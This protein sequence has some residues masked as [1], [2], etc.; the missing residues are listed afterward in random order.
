MLSILDTFPYPYR[1]R[2]AQQL[3]VTLSQLHPTPQG[4]ILIA[5]QAGLDGTLIDAGQPP[6]FVWKDVLGLAGR[7]GLTRQLVQL[8]HDKLNATNPRRPFLAGLLSGKPTPADDEPRADGGAPNFLRDTD[9]V[10][11]DE[12]L[13]YHD[14]LT[15]QIGRLPDFIDTLQRMV[16]LAPAVC[17]LT[18]D[19]HGA[20]MLG[21][22]FRIGPDLLLTNWHVVYNTLTGARATAVTAEFGYEH[23][24]RG[25]AL[26]A[27]I[28]TCDVESIVPGQADD[29]AV[30][31]ATDPLSDAWPVVKLSEAVTPEKGSAAYVIQHPGGERKRLGFVR[32]TVTAFDERTMHYLTDT[33][34]GSS[35]APVF[36]PRGR[37]IALHHAG[38][39]PQQVVGMP[40]LRKNEGIRIPR[41]IDGLRGRIAVP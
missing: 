33:R 10:Y 5:S 35:G 2:D 31:R 30:I 6:F 32:N 4:A 9:D 26:A 14:D 27:K 12:T 3:H 34:E 29:W 28:V 7:S 23:D 17:R 11:E 15:I 8:V 1:E 37:L 41:I 22:A 21:T 18:V 16:R 36:D 24:G 20:G 13:L 38:G 40:P 39:R 19:I 25:T